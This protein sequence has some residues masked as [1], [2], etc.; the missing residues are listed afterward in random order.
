MSCNYY[1]SL[2]LIVFDIYSSQQWPASLF[3]VKREFEYFRGNYVEKVRQYKGLPLPIIIN[4]VAGLFTL[5]DG[6]KQRD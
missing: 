2:Q 3:D 5:V 6:N 1:I 4:W